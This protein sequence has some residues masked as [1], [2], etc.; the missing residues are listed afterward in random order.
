MGADAPFEAP[1]THVTIRHG[2]RW[3]GAVLAWGMSASVALAQAP[4]AGDA[5]TPSAS[6][7]TPPATRVEQI[8]LARRQKDATLWPERE[9][10]LVA[11]VNRLLDRGLIEGIRTG[12]GNN[13]WQLILEGTRP[14]NGQTYGIGYRRADLFNDLLTARATARATFAGAQ[15]Y[16]GELQLNRRRRFG[17][18][19]RQRLREVRTIAADG[20]LRSWCRLPEG[21]P[22]PVS[23][24]YGVWSRLGR[25]T[26]SRRALNAGVDF[27]YGAAHTG[28]VDGR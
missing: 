1:G 25:A 23:A 9:H 15:L 28:P 10:P 21:R 2:S 13:G 24:E 19:I 11:R 3:L 7:A 5:Q 26:A 8:E 12:E 4:T 18:R 17:G 14:A 20:L 6:P 22:H 16:D 27:G